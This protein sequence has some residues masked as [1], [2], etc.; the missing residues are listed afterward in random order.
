LLALSPV[1]EAAPTAS[2]ILPRISAWPIMVA[3][4]QADIRGKMLDAVGAASITGDNASNRASRGHWQI[5]QRPTAPCRYGA[6]HATRHAS[7]YAQSHCVQIPAAAPAPS[8]SLRAPRLGYLQ[9][10]V[11]RPAHPHSACAKPETA[12]VERNQDIAA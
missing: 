8:T 1:I 12:P 4:E 10:H 7:L 6:S 9:K 3:A 11:T 5:T 2:S